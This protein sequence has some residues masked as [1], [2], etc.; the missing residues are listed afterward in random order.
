M[1][2]QIGLID[3]LLERGA[4]VNAARPDGLRPIHLTNGDYHYRGWRDLPDTALQ[5]HDV[6]IGYLLA[7]GAH[8]D[9]PTACKLGDL[10]RVRELLDQD[11]E[12]LDKLPT[13]SYYTGLPL[14][15]AAAAGHYQVVKLLLDRGADPNRPEPGIAPQGGALHAALGARHWEVAEL[16]LEHG[17][18]P[19]APVES[20]GN[21]LFIAKHAGAPKE[22]MALLVSY[23]AVMGAGLADLET[24]GAMLHANP[25]LEVGERADSP[26]MLKLILRYQPDLLRRSPDPTPW[27][28]HATPPTA[29]LARWA[30]TQG[31]D[32]NRRNWLGITALHRCAA[33]GETSVAEAFLEAG[34]D[35]DAMET[36]WCSTPLGWAAREGKAEMAAWLLERGAHPGLP[37]DEP[38]ARPVEW[39]RR[40]GHGEVLR[41]LGRFTRL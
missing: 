26:E 25:N 21:C 7:R 15:N 8:Y 36:E 39:A 33:K 24:L 18:N 22:V 28:S 41:V 37:E 1:T 20:S 35:I 17:A 9:L 10:E 19:N 12:L 29:E 34:A 16:L 3:Y 14:R 27:W 2:R 40:R 38:W 32:P 4:D 11:P 6:L 31:L 5:R 13:Y 30:F 23:G